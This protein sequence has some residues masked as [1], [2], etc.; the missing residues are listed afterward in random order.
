MINLVG[1]NKN[2]GNEGGVEVVRNMLESLL[3][4]IVLS[5]DVYISFWLPTTILLLY[6]HRKNKNVVII[7]YEHFEP[8][9]YSLKWKLLR[10]V[11]YWRVD[12]IVCINEHQRE[13]FKRFFPTKVTRLI[14]NPLKNFPEINNFTKK[15]KILFVGHLRKLKRV[16]WII[17]FTIANQKLIRKKKYSID[18]CGDGPEKDQLLDMVIEGGV[19]DIVFFVG[20]VKDIHVKYAESNILVLPSESEGYPLVLIEALYWNCIPISFEYNK[21]IHNILSSENIFTSQEHMNQIL[22]NLISNK[23]CYID[24]KNVL[25]RHSIKRFNKEWIDL[26]NGYQ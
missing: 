20:Y 2:Y 18:I 22:I 24:T 13:Y 3:G 19:G 21:S 17:D 15:N 16:N 14:Y 6:K 25:K 11:F 7:C 1:I 4:D 23:I 12:L 26:L 8:N 10:F 5:K 9:Y